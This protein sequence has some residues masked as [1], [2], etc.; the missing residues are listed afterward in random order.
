M[1]FPMKT[2]FGEAYTPKIENNFMVDF[3]TI[4]SLFTEDSISI[5]AKYTKHSGRTIVE[6]YDLIYGLKTRFK[7][8]THFDQQ[9]SVP[10]RLQTIKQEIIQSPGSSLSDELNTVDE[11]PEEYKHSSCECQICNMVNDTIENW[12]S[13]ISQVYDSLS[14]MDKS[15][16]E[17]IFASEKRVKELD[18]FK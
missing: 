11:N 1:N 9:E 15:V 17:A 8:R 10:Q 7:H 14:D 18:Q 12:D 13:Y 5:A 2:G 4:F 3:A 16:V 6:T